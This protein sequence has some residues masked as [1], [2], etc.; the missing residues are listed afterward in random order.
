MEFELGVVQ[1]LSG[2]DDDALLAALDEALRSRLAIEQGQMQVPRYSFSHS[3]VR[4]TLYEELNLRRRQRL[5]LRAAE[6]IEMVHSQHA[7]PAHIAALATHYRNAGALAD[8]E[9]AIGY[10][11]RAAE[12]ATGV[13]AWDE[14]VG[15]YEGVLQILELKPEEES[16]RC[17]FLLSLGWTLMPSGETKRV[18]ESVA[19]DAMTIA[20]R[21]G[22]EKRA[23]AACRLATEAFH[24]AGARMM[25]LTDQWQGWADAY[26]R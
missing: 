3:L 18:M 8:I 7:T 17:D 5:H 16:R 11:V 22:D 26:E 4:Q 23:A 14:A 13:F 1:H 10:S 24:R 12:A 2:L 6:A 19:P 20:E 21:I 9:K 25:T 15:H